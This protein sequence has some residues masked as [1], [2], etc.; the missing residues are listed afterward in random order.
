MVGGEES[1]SLDLFLMVSHSIHSTSHHI[2]LQS[3]RE[4]TAKRLT[5][6]TMTVLP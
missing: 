3:T 4:T 5:T 1:I 6:L 2:L